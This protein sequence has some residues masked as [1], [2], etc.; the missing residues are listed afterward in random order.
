M[1]RSKR[2][3]SSGHNRTGR[4]P[5]WPLSRRVVVAWC[6]HAPRQLAGGPSQDGQAHQQP[7]AR[8][9]SCRWPWFDTS[10]HDAL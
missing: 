4:Y 6:V 8:H 10:I 3:L 5:E 2:V 7:T 9:G 1:E